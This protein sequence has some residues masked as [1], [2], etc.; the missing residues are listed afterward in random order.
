MLAGELMFHFLLTVIITAIVATFVLWRYRVVVLKGMSFASGEPV[1][2]TPRAMT[3]APSAPAAAGDSA[4]L[5]WERAMHRRAI[6]AWLI[7]VAVPAPLIA[8]AYLS[9][10]QISAATIVMASGVILGAAVPVIAVS[11]GWTWKRG[12]LFWLEL[13]A[14]GAVLTVVAS[15]LQRLARGASPSLDQLLNVLPFFQ[16]AAVFSSIPL[17]LVLASGPGR[18]RG[19]VPITFAGLLVFGLAPV[20]GSRATQLLAESRAGSELLLGTI[21]TVGLHAAFIAFAL[22]TGWIAWKRLQA[23]AREY[24]EKGFSDVQLLARA[25]WLMFIATL[26]LEILNKQAAPLW[27]VITCAAAYPVFLVAN[28]HAFRWVGLAAANR[29]PRTLLLLRV[30]GYTRRTEKLFDRVGSRWRYFGPVTMIAAPDVVARSIDPADFLYYMVGAIDEN[31]V[32]SAADLQR[33][34]Q[35]LDTQRDPDG[36][37]RVNDFCCAD[38]TWRATV[39]ALMD[40]ADV[41]LMDLR[42]ITSRQRG[43]EFELREL[44]TRLAPQRVVLVVDNATDRTFVR[45]ALGPAADAVQF[46]EM[47]K[48]RTAATD[49]LF[50]ELIR[51][52]G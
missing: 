9:G 20:L 34:L 36:R 13:L 47:D 38:T 12:L 4:A 3:H 10:E 28:R 19:V 43:C 46:Y 14:A 48:P 6:C 27:A 26:A 17:L 52:A 41:V 11:L 25:W 2:I 18:L 15:M 21:S 37:F 16:L 45:G 24:E 22:P 31:F 33:R 42:G 8:V 49:K 32:R 35:T 50:R 29:V 39:T 44:P 40:R 30:F 51:A 5:A 1:A 7:T 23:V